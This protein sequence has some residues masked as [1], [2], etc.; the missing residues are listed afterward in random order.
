MPGLCGLLRLGSS[1]MPRLLRS[2]RRLLL[3][4]V[5]LEAGDRD[6]C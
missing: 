6:R 4:A 3:V 2:R 5:K 1:G